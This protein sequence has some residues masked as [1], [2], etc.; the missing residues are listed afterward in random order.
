MPARTLSYQ[1]LQIALVLANPKSHLGQRAALGVHVGLNPSRNPLAATL[2]NYVFFAREPQS[3]PHHVASRQAGATS[4]ERRT[5]TDGSQEAD[6]WKL[7]FL[8]RIKTKRER[9][10]PQP[11][12]TS[13]RE[14]RRA[15]VRNSARASLTGPL[16]WARWGVSRNDGRFMRPP[17]I[18]HCRPAVSGADRPALYGWRERRG[19]WRS[20]R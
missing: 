2:G 13:R 19:F 7:G 1:A 18:C 17:G 14:F 6:A 16:E 3:Q 8:R 12:A 9:C 4:W 10:L 5:Q 20:W 15:P 11:L